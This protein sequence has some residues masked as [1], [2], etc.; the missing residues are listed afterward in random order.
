[1]SS[2]SHF[3][4][5]AA[6]ARRILHLLGWRNI[7]FIRELNRAGHTVYKSG[8]LW[9]WFSGNRGVPHGVAIFLRLSVRIAV[10]KRRLADRR[11]LPGSTPEDT[12]CGNS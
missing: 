2:E 3:G 10:L 8:D 9:K 6:R 4:M 7:D 11:E 12:R 1:M 5:S